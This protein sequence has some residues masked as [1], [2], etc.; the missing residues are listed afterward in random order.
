M[1]MYQRDRFELLSAYLDG[2]VTATERQQIELWLTT[3]PEVQRLYARALKLRPEW[4][5]MPVPAAQQPMKRTVEFVLP[6]LR[7]KTKMATWAGTVLTTVLFGTLSAILPPHRQSPVLTMT[8]ALQP[9]VKHNPNA[10]FK[11][12]ECGNSQITFTGRRNIR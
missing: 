10:C 9:M 5:T 7:A 3:D 6:G 12:A 4:G 2:E 11:Y 1:D 8:Q